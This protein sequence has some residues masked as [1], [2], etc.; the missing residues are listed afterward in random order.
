MRTMVL[1]PR[2]R[3]AQRGALE[4]LIAHGLSRH[5]AP[6]AIRQVLTYL[7]V[8]FLPFYLYTLAIALITQ[9]DLDFFQPLWVLVAVMYVCE[10]TFAVRKGGWRAVLVSLAIAP[11]IFLDVYLD[12]VYVVA[13]NGALF[14]TDEKWG[15]VRDL[16]AAEF[17]RNGNPRDGRPRP[18]S[19]ALHGT[20]ARRRNLRSRALQI[21]LAVLGIAVVL[22]AVALPLISLHTAWF[23][24]AVYVLTGFLATIGRLIPVRTF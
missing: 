18:A 15:R 11:E 5:T 17:D 22:L 2:P 20:H 14:A 21:G 23:I 19:S 3:A 10:Q 4:N 8:L 1:L 13:L 24:L 9:S 6:Y 12:V 16:D 7:G